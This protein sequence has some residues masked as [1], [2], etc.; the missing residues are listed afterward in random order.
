MRELEKPVARVFRRLRYQRFLTVL[1]WSLALTL[2]IVAGVIAGEKLLNRSLPGPAW[3]PFAAAGLTGL[4]FAAAISLA[5]GPSRMDAAIALDRV[6]HL[7][8]RVSSALSLPADLRESPA[9]LALIADATRKVSDLDVGAEF[10]LRLPRRA[11][12]VLIPATT[13][14][15]L[16]FAPALIPKLAQIKAAEKVDFKAIAKQTEMLHQENRQ[17]APGNRQGKVPRGRQAPGARSRRK[18]TTSPRP[19]RPAKTS[20]WSS[21]IR[22]PTSSRNVRNSSGRRNRSIASSSSSRIWRSQGPADEF[23][24]DLAKG[25]FKKAAEQLQKLQEKLQSGKMIGSREK[26]PQG[27]DRRNGQEA[28]RSGQPRTAQEA[29]RGSSQERRPDPAAIRARDGKTQ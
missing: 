17:P 22:S 4:V 9:G 26:G 1:I 10:G 21:S 19:R 27:T 14:V 12:V 16:L 13:A 24:K 23:V 2:L 3:L 15:L 28:E 20:S 6:F 18:P 5:T 7:N 11:W 8:E 25:D 29:A